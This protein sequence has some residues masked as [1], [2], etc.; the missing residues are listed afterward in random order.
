M[1]ATFNQNR[2]VKDANWVKTKALPAAGATNQT[3]TFDLHAAG[4][5]LPEEISVEVSIPA[6]AA[7][8]SASYSATV[9]VQ[10]ST[11]DVTYAN[12]DDGTNSLP[13]IDI[14]TPGVASTG[15]AARVVRFKLPSGIARYIQ[16]QQAVTSGGPTLTGTTIT[17]SLLF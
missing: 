15:S 8:N 2:L 11:D 17:Y 3:A 14:D 13:D 9:T 16:F 5:P 4:T 12:L 6:M 1:A 10:Q 7:N